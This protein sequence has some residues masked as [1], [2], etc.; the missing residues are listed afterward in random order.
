MILIILY[1]QNGPVPNSYKQFDIEKF[2]DNSTSQIIPEA[3]Q[4]VAEELS[5]FKELGHL[6][7]EVFTLFGR[8][9]ERK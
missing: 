7:P 9:Y 1:N 5:K 8:V 4:R 2:L 6:N 3:K